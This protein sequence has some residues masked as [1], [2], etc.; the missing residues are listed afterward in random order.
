MFQTLALNK[1]WIVGSYAAK[2]I[3]YKQG[4]SCELKKIGF[5]LKNQTLVIKHVQGHYVGKGKGKGRAISG[6]ALRAQEL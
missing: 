6:Q 2:N 1:K 4:T 3:L 5:V